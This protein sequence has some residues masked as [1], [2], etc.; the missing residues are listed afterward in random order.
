MERIIKRE[1]FYTSQDFYMSA[2]LMAVGI[3]LQ[4]YRRDS[5]LTTFVFVSSQELEE[6]VREYY[7]MEARV[8]PVLYANALRNLKSIIHSDIK[9]NTHYV[10]QPSNNR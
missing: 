10:E 5:G 8:N 3:N 4:T 7:A 9:P 2:Y 1:T 6:H